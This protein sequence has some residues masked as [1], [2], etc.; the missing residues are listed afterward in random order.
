LVFFRAGGWP[1]GVLFAGLTAVDICEFFFAQIG[2]RSTTAGGSWPGAKPSRPAKLAV[3]ALGFF[4]LLT[5]MWLMY[6][7]FTTTLDMA[8]GFHLPGA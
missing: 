5:G 6:L 2:V 4:H 3:R 8:S 7:T 1:V